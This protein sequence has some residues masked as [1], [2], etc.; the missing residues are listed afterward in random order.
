M[1]Q[2]QPGQ[3][4]N[5]EG[6]PKGIKDKRI[7]FAEIIESSNKGLLNKALEMAL[8]GNEQ[9]LKMF[10]ERILPAKPKDNLVNVKLTGDTLTEKSKQVIEALSNQY[11]TPSEAMDMMQTLAMQARVFDADELAKFIR[12]GTEFIKTYKENVRR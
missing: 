12:K 11:I 7:L 4:G 3:S 2:F 9:M 8:D 10:L 6:R 5:S 1:A